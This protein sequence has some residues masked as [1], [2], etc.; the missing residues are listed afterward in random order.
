MNDSETVL[1]KRSRYEIG[2]RVKIT[3]DTYSEYGVI[4]MVDNLEPVSSFPYGVTH[5]NGMRWFY[6]D[7][8]IEG[9]LEQ[10]RV[11]EGGSV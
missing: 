9:R 5:D 1:Q 10:V 6:S 2:D 8:R 11:V 4:F 7:D 3:G